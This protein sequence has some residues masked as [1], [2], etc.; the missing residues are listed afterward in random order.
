MNS[1]G[2]EWVVSLEKIGIEVEPGNQDGLMEKER[3]LRGAMEGLHVMVRESQ[4]PREVQGSKTVTL[5][6]GALQN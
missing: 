2:N 1:I 3:S 5:Q 6:R 4:G